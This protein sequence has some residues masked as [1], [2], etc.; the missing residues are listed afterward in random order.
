MQGEQN[1]WKSLDTR[2]FFFKD[3]QKKLM[4]A[5]K[6]NDELRKI[7]GL[8]TRHKS[9]NQLKGGSSKDH[10]FFCTFQTY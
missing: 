8:A 4:A 9:L 10:E 1:F 3:Q 6:Q 2:Q 7:A 5:K